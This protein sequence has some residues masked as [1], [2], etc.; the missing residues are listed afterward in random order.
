MAYM[1]TFKSLTISLKVPDIGRA[2]AFYSG[3]GFELTGT[4]EFHYGEGNVNWA[5]MRNG[6]AALMLGTDGN[7]VPKTSQ[8]F[9]LTVEDTDALCEAIRDSVTILHEPQDRFYG[10]RDFWF[11]DPFGFQWGAGHALKDDE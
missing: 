9:F 8:Q 4:D 10:M 3:L 1:Q 6:G 2:V 7:D 11:S 5:M